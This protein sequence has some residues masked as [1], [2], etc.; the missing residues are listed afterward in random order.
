MVTFPILNNL[1]VLETEKP[2]STQN[3]DQLTYNN[4]ITLK[5]CSRDEHDIITNSGMKGNKGPCRTGK[6]IPQSTKQRQATASEP[7]LPPNR[8]PISHLTSNAQTPFRHSSLEPPIATKKPH[9]TISLPLF[10]NPVRPAPR[11][12]R[13][14]PPPPAHPGTLSNMLAFW[15]SGI[16]DPC[17]AYHRAERAHR[18]E[19]RG[20]GH[21]EKPAICSSNPVSWP[22]QGG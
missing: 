2:H 9:Q 20:R 1:I 21:G 15:K 19:T 17:P 14:I 8:R 16:V 3:V 18:D 6:H 22:N 7:C 4:L 5:G 13:R 12:Q 11:R 10:R